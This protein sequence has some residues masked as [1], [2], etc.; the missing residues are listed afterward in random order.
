MKS[1]ETAL[2][3][4]VVSIIISLAGTATLSATTVMLSPDTGGEMQL[5]SINYAPTGFPFTNSG[6]YSVGVGEIVELKVQANSGYVIDKWF[7]NGT[8]AAFLNGSDHDAITVQGPTEVR[9][10]FKANISLVPDTGGKM[11]LYSVNYVPTG[12][13]FTN[14]AT[15][16]VSVGDIVELKTV[17]DPGREID[18]WF[19]NGTNAAFLNGS[20]HDAITVQGPTTVRVSFD[21]YLE[22]LTAVELRFQAKTNRQYQFEKSTDLLTWTNDGPLIQGQGTVHT[23]FRSTDGIPKTF[24]RLVITGN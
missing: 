2:A 10:S 6:S 22:I 8:N 19:Y 14:S 4:A 12:F 17:A 3:V 21:P 20:D 16:P 9:V 11:Q 18:K 13:P 24:Y 5:Y 1:I 7:Y 15:Y 23:E